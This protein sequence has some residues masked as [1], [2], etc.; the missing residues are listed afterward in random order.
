MKKKPFYNVLFAGRFRRSGDAGFSLDEETYAPSAYSRS[1]SPGWRG[2]TYLLASGWSMDLLRVI[3]H[4]RCLVR[5]NAPLP[6]GLE[7]TAHEETRAVASSRQYK[8]TPWQ[9]ILRACAWFYLIVYLLQGLVI[10][11]SEGSFRLPTAV[12]VFMPPTMIV[13][14][15]VFTR[16]WRFSSAGAFALSLGACISQYLTYFT[17]TPGGTVAGI[18]R[19]TYH[20]DMYAIAI[21]F[22]LALPVLLILGMAAI[23]WLLGKS[24]LGGIRREAV[25]LKLR[26]HLASGHDL[27][28]A[29]RRLPRFFPRV[30]AELVA[31]GEASGQIEKC[32][33][34]LNEET[35]DR[36]KTRT[37]LRG[38]LI[39]LGLVTLIQTL[40]LSFIAV[41][42]LPVF[43]EIVAEFSEGAHVQQ[44]FLVQLGAVLLGDSGSSYNPFASL[45]MIV[46][47]LVLVLLFMVSVGGLLFSG[48]ALTSAFA[49]VLLR[50]PGLGGMLVRRH[51][52][53]VVVALER[54]LAAGMPLEEALE[55]AAV[56]APNRIHARMLRRMRARI[57]QGESLADAAQ[58]ETRTVGV[59]SS[60]PTMIAVG[61]HAG[62][63]PE[64]LRYLADNYAIQAR[65]RT[66]LLNAMVQPMGVLILG[67]LTLTIL[68]YLY[69]MMFSVTEVVL[70]FTI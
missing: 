9:W 52:A 38:T 6:A 56:C 3:E 59:P 26:D 45:P 57:L 60:F 1:R 27:S 49:G 63:L 36:V 11:S 44:S 40:L 13:L 50:M 55:C 39:Y 35:L 42:V 58:A 2:P 43:R 66:H 32:L 65:N 34:D 62:M 37:S 10:I 12:Y 48:S 69:G 5:V 25:L 53:V 15:M 30:F 61:E 29:M 17:F 54:L 21:I 41:R 23:H 70:E 67:V 20:R 33:D 19:S 47:A 31:A 68:V 16:W 14:F 51:L 7:A 4:I 22:F 24:W 28:E 8:S 64:A 46:F 18:L